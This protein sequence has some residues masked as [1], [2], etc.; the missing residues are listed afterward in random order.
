MK[1]DATKHDPRPEYIRKL[2]ERSGLSQVKAAAAIGVD[3]RTMRRYVLGEASA[4]Y[5]VQFALECLAKC[6]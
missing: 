4:P 2:I 3:P 1:P 5:L 6:R